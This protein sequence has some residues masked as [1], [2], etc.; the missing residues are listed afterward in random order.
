MAIFKRFLFFVALLI[1]AVVPV[2]EAGGLGPTDEALKADMISN[3]DRYLQSN[4]VG[5]GAVLYID[6]HSINVE[7]YEPPH[8]TISYKIHI[9]S[10]PPYGG[11]DAHQ[12]RHEKI[13]YNWDERRAFIYTIN[14]ETKQMVWEEIARNDNWWRYIMVANQVFRLAY[15]MD[16]F[17]PD[18]R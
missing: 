8:Y 11:W 6:K 10:Y 17:P 4:G 15:N 14:P 5:T 16:F 9:V 3:P 2:A 18:K 7:Q 13:Y 1:I 12:P